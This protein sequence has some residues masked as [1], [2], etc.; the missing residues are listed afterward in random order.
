MRM[1]RNRWKTSVNTSEFRNIFAT[2]VLQV[3]E[4]ELIIGNVPNMGPLL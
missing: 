3:E 1:P 2:S 4:K